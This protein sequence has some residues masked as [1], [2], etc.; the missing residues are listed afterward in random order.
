MKAKAMLTTKISNRGKSFMPREKTG[1][2]QIN[3]IVKKFVAMKPGES[4]FI[5][6]LDADDV[7]WLRRP[8][9]AAGCGITIRRVEH[10]EI[11]LQAGVRIWREEGAYDE[12]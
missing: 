10:D 5:A 3:V 8:A 12:L 11:Y 4:F 1:Q 7:E 2:Q 9:V 6:D